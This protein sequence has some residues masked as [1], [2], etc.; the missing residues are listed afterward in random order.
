M[1]SEEQVLVLKRTIR[2]LT[3]APNQMTDQLKSDIETLEQ[4]I[5]E[6][7]GDTRNDLRALT[8]SIFEN[9]EF[10]EGFTCLDC[11]LKAEC[12]T[13]NYSSLDAYDEDPE[14]FCPNC[15]GNNLQFHTP[16]EDK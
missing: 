14:P 10:N 7:G 1:N 3:A 5:T 2:Y 9:S 4:M 12:E 16:A 6:L 13:L 15:E 8:I 11:G